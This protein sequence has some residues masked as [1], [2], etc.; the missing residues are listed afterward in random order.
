[1]LLAAMGA[2]EGALTLRQAAAQ[3]Q[4]AIDFGTLAAQQAPAGHS[5][6]AALEAAREAKGWIDDKIPWFASD[7]PP[8]PEVSAKVTE[9][10]AGIY[11]AAANLRIPGDVPTKY[12]TPTS[13]PWPWIGGGLAALAGTFLLFRR[14]RR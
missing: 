2:D 6:F 10:V 8:L 13:L 1:M 14:R 7:S 9:V 11:D 12:D 3:V 5:I 4:D